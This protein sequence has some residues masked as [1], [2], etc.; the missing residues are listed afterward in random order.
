MIL[1]DLIITVMGMH[2]MSGYRIFG[3]SQKIQ[4]GPRYNSDTVDA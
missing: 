4:V 2:V 1:P 3:Q